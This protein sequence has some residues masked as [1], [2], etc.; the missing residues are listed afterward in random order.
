MKVEEPDGFDM[1]FQYVNWNDDDSQFG[2]ETERS[3]F[4]TLDSNITLFD[5]L[6]CD[7]GNLSPKTT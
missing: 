4:G 5:G 7:D 2:G 6:A 1:E 3:K